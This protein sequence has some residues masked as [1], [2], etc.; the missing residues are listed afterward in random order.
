[1]CSPAQSL[2]RNDGGPQAQG[3]ADEGEHHSDHVVDALARLDLWMIWHHGGRT[4]LGGYFG[5]VNARA[6][7]TID[8]GPPY[9]PTTAL[10]VPR[11]ALSGP[12]AGGF[13]IWGDAET[14]PFPPRA[15]IISCTDRQPG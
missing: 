10:V 12:K 8:N 15:P 14:C 11:P 6:A 2:K 1:V 3:D 9:C 13:Q 7:A 4:I 5:S